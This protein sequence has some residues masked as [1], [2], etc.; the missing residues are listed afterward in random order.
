MHSFGSLWEWQVA[1]PHSCCWVGVLPKAKKG[2]I[3]QEDFYVDQLP[4][5]CG[6]HLTTIERKG[7]KKR[8]YMRIVFQPKQSL[9]VAFEGGGQVA[10]TKDV[11]AS[12]HLVLGCGTDCGRGGTATVHF[13]RTTAV[14]G[15]IT[16]KRRICNVS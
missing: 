5:F 8:L 9:S 12:G 10:I 11:P 13:V 14:S 15:P 16:P 6:V 7:S 4:G 3:G 2:L 1:A